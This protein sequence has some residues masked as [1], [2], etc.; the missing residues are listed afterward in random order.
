MQTHSVKLQ[1]NIFTQSKLGEMLKD[2]CEDCESSWWGK[3][4]CAQNVRK[5]WKFRKEMQT[6]LLSARERIASSESANHHKIN[7][8]S[9]LF[10]LIWIYS[11]PATQKLWQQNLPQKEVY[12]K[13]ESRHF[14]FV[15]SSSF[16]LVASSIF[17]RPLW[18][19]AI[20]IIH[21]IL[22]A[23]NTQYLL[24][25]SFEVDCIT[26][27]WTLDKPARL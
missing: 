9:S 24:S 5:V 11:K 27:M 14:G 10:R 26:H 6:P 3:N 17:C 21:H 12:S 23:H 1:G 19:M 15:H 25:Q 18:P 2:I 7:I 22:L 8:I 16:T 13:C 4:Y 20:Y